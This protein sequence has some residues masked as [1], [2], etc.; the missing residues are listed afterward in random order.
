MDIK[1]TSEEYIIR[2]DVPGYDKGEISL[3][4]HDDRLLIKAEKHEEVEEKGESFIRRERGYR[5]FSRTISIP[6]DALPEE[7][8]D[9]SLDKGVLEIRLKRAPNEEKGPRK[10]EIK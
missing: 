9:A 1:V 5:S 8:I 4:L 7:D 3:E 6:E 2:A 10:I